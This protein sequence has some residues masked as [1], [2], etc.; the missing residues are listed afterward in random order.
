MTSPGS[1][2]TSR[3]VTRMPVVAASLVA[4]VLLAGCA[5][6]SSAAT[7]HDASEPLPTG[8]PADGSSLRVAGRQTQ[9]QL[10]AAGD[11]IDPLAFTVDEWVNA[12]A[13]PDVIQAFRA[14]ALDI[15]NNAIIPPI[16]AHDIGFDA[17][18]V[19][20]LERPSP[21][22]VFATAPGVDLDSFE[23]L[24]G[25]KIAFS[26][27]QSQG[28][29]VL[30]TLQTAGI[31]VDEV[32]F[33]ELPSTQFLTAL[34]SGQVDVAPLGEPV[35]TKYIDQFGKDGA[36]AL[37]AEEPDLLS[38]LWVPNTV[39]ADADKVL[40]VRDYIRAWAQGQV[41]A[42]ENAD[43]W[44]KFYFVDTEGVSAEDADRIWALANKPSF[45]K[46]WDDAD[47]WAQSSAD[48]LSDGG[49][50]EGFDTEVLF[51]RRFEGDAAAAVADEYVKE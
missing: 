18:I 50:I 10:E 34:Q 40:A 49:Y 21:S 20:V 30:R 5:S 4:L 1:V 38:V 44:K 41:W 26:Q 24:R 32:D 35:V 36:V 9:L 17:S 37:P 19:A 45:P 16:Q 25:K 11:A 42:W 39:L 43:A 29:T 2:R 13:G 27:G 23:G 51:D 28:D 48:L 31:D 14:G 22:Y 6:T 3:P 8:A 12:Q 46:N 33:V 15:A 7:E 47:A